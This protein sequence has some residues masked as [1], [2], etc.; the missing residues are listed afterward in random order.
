MNPK[1]FFRPT[2]EINPAGSP[3]TGESVFI[4]VGKIRRAHGVEGEILVQPFTQEPERFRKGRIIYVGESYQPI[5]IT[6]RRE[7]NNGVL[8]QLE[9]VV[10]P[11]QVAEYRNKNLYINSSSLPKLPDGEYYHFQLIGLR[12]ENEAGDFIGNLSEIITTGSN[13]VYVAKD[14]SGKESLFPA[15]PSVVLSIDMETRRMVVRPQE[16]L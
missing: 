16:W 6:E 8:I 13:D 14:D 15:I 10:N 4:L 9:G 7:I 5:R 3:Q 1:K 11:E 12:V 2:E